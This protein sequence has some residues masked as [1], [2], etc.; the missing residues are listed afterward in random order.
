[1]ELQLHLVLFQFML[2]LKQQHYEHTQPKIG[3]DPC[4]SSLEAQDGSDAEKLAEAFVAHHKTTATDAK[5]ALTCLKDSFFQIRYKRRNHLALQA[6]CEELSTFIKTT[7]FKNEFKS[8]FDSARLNFGTSSSSSSSPVATTPISVSSSELTRKREHDN[9][10][11][12]DATEHPDH[13]SI[14]TVIKR[15]AID[16][17]DT[18][19]QGTKLSE[20]DRKLMSSGLSSILDLVDQSNTGQAK[21]FA[22]HALNTTSDL[23]LSKLQ[24]ASYRMP[25]EVT[26]NWKLVSALAKNNNDLTAARSFLAKWKSG[27]KNNHLYKIISVMEVFIDVFDKQHSYFT[28]TLVS[29]WTEYDY[30]LKIWGPIIEDH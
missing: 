9:L 29:R 23:L 5:G 26:K 24:V 27:T 7:A 1:M 28:S 8:A 4:L 19:Q 6:Y 25:L 10:Y 11:A 12:D 30:L 22:E 17:H 18:Y 13:P 16:L 15:R 14:G 3:F 2:L 20:A 21:W